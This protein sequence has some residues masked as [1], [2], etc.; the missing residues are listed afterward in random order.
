M[1]RTNGPWLP[2]PPPPSVWALN[3]KLEPFPAFLKAGSAPFRVAVGTGLPY[4]PQILLYLD[5]SALLRSP[6]GK[7]HSAGTQLWPV[8]AP[9]KRVLPLP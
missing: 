2:A 7:P 9:L 5:Q 4:F 1:K 8:W 3:S 6:L